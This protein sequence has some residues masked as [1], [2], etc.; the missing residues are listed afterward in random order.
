[1]SD[2]EWFE[3]RRFPDGVTMIGEPHHRED[4]KVYLIEGDRDVAVLD[5][6]TGAGDFSGLV[7]SLSSRRPRILQTHAHWDHIGASHRFADV[8][9]HPAEAEALRVGFPADRYTAVFSGDAVA[10]GRLPAEFDPGPGIPGREPTGWLEHGDRIDLGQRELEVLH[11]PGH[12]PGGVSFLDRQARALFVGDLL[13]LG[14]M[15]LFFPGSDPTA[16]RESL[17]LVAGLAG[18]VETVYPAHNETP[19]VAEEM[20]AI[21]DAYETVWAG[22]APDHFGSAYGY[23]VA[24]H[25]F[26]RYSFLLPDSNPTP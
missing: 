20:V 7:A 25:D 17:R 4:V 13:Y 12:S 21:R 15:L 14:R 18:E 16:F 24:I 23:R 19:I 8:L 1:M 3:V 11:T 9:V 22:R 2:R 10:P 26:G 6:G 5:T